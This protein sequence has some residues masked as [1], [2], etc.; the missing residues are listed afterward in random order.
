MFIGIFIFLAGLC[1]GSFL[2]VC[3]YRIP[4]EKSVVFPPSSCPACGN[5]LKAVDMIP[6]LS[7]IGLKG[8]CRSCKAPISAQYPIVELLTGILWVLVYLRYGLSFEALALTFFF[9]LLIPVFFIDFSQLIIPDELVI[10]G[11]IG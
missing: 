8:K 3:I 10:T 4:L 2:N 5:R 6:V 1:A 7:Y 11:L 9:S